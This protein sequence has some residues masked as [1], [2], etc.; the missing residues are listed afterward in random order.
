[1]QQKFDL[2][3]GNLPWV[4]VS[5]YPKGYTGFVKSV[6][7]DLNVLPPGQVAKKLDISIPLFAVALKHL[8]SSPS[9]TALMVPCSILRGLHGAE[10]RN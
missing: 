10:I 4:N 5:K 3:L 9:I 2:V 1:V 6:A 8:A 7:K